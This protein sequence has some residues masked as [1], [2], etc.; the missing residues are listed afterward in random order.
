MT[1]AQNILRYLEGRPELQIKHEKQGQYR[2]NSPLRPGSN[3]HG[4]TLT[5][6]AD[7]EHG[8]FIDHVSG[9]SGSLF[10]LADRL[11]IEKTPTDR[12]APVE[13]KRSYSGLAEYAAAHYAPVEAFAAAL[14]VEMTYQNR[15]AL[16]FPTKTGNR[17]RFIDGDK[18][19][20]KSERDYSQCWYGLTR[21][22]KMA[23]AGQPLVICNGEPSTITAQHW[24]IAAACI[25]SG[26]K[27]NIPGVL[28]KELQQVYHTGPIIIALDCDKTGRDAGLGI[29]AKL[30]EAGYQARAVDLRGGKGFDLADFCGLYKADAAAALLTLPELATAPTATDAPATGEGEG[31]PTHDELAARWLAAAPLTAHGLGD[32][33]RYEAGIWLVCPDAIIRREV[34]DVL[35]GAKGEGTRPTTATLASVMEFCRLNVWQ[36]DRLWDAD[37]DYLVCRNGALN[38]PT[39]TLHPH[40]AELYATSGVDYDFDPDAEAPNWD[41]FLWDLNAETGFFLQEF[42]GYALTIGTQYEIAVWLYGPPGGG[43]STFLAGLQAMLGDRAGLLG[44]ADIERSRFAL[45][46]L[47]GKTLAIATEQPGSFITA[48]HLLNAIISGEPIT[49]ERKFKEALTIS[50]RAKLCWAMNE[51]PRVSDPNSGLFRRVK[52]VEFPAIA[53]D[54]RDPMLKENIAREGAGILNWALIGLERLR[55]RGRFDVPAAVIGATDS[56]KQF[57]DI[58]AN[59][60]AECCITGPD[61]RA[62]ATELYNAYRQWCESNGHKPQS[63]TSLATDWKRM[64]FEK[65]LAG[66]RSNWRFV[67]LKAA[68]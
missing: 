19:T 26:E 35:T 41:K 42:A 55:K 27:P 34:L 38:I 33:R 61:C 10:S 48:A 17:W 32:W 1:T 24:G 28:V 23:G 67:G 13:T 36:D 5:I 11:G 29:A 57:N 18:P 37:P 8:A 51:L 45:A 22:V 58:P 16:R 39:A 31:R 66:G 49:V 60:V 21:A 7:G 59:F 54:K 68:G 43:K 25:T 15:P 12:P 62:G 44:L 64:G 52:V 2:L 46:G 20:F 40:K 56:F 50:P 65:Y 3:S 30:K 4:F 47:P 14:W 63:S 6:E 9:E 53:P